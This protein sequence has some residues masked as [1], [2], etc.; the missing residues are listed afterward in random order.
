[1]AV[2]LASKF[3]PIEPIKQSFD[4][5]VVAAWEKELKPEFVIKMAMILP[6]MAILRQGFP[7]AS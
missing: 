2:L 4:E 1:M 6:R 3:T 7:P 5:F